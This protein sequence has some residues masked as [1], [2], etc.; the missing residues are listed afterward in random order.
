MNDRKYLED[1]WDQIDACVFS[2]DPFY[3]AAL[4]QDFRDFMAR[5][6]RGL[7]EFDRAEARQLSEDCK[8]SLVSAASF[9]Q[10]LFDAGTF[11]NC[12][13]HPPAVRLAPSGLAETMLRDVLDFGIPYITSPE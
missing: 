11:V 13:D 6:E 9:K 5:W 10:K 3:D 7:K 1:L 8:D 4:R 2:G 12:P